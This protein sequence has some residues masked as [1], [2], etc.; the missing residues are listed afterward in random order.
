MSESKFRSHIAQHLKSIRQSRELSLDA[1]SKLTGVSKAMLGQIERQE[2]SPTIS[3]LWQIASG[4]NTSFSA[5]FATDPEMLLSSNTFPDDQD[6]QVKTIFTYQ[7][8]TKM[9]MFEIELTNNH[10][11]MS[12]PHAIGVIEHVCVLSGVL[13]V[14]V[15]DKWRTIQC[16]ETIR[17]HADQIHGYRAHSQCAVFQN[18][19]CYT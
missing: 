18:I 1:T 9:E 17:F 4:L 2:S 3:K 11:Q 12:D 16:G 10:Q 15:D 13:D 14:Y 8:D 7:A 5:F 19:V 6:M